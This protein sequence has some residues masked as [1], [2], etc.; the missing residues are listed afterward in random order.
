MI[1]YK[2]GIIRNGKTYLIKFI[3]NEMYFPT[4]SYWHKVMDKSDFVQFSN[5]FT[6]LEDQQDIVAYEGEVT[7]WLKA[8][9]IMDVINE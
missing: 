3:D 7:V 9:I 8:K 4:T 1:E 6:L 2:V 5:D